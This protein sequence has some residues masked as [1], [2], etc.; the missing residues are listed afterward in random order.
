MFKLVK[1]KFKEIKYLGDSIGDDIRI[2]VE[3]L[4][5]FLRVD[6]KIKNGATV[7]INKE[8]AQIETNEKLFSTEIFINIFEKDLLFNDIGRV[9][10][11][12]KIDV[13]STKPQIFT[14]EIKI[15][16]THSNI[17]KPWSKA[18]A[19][20]EVKLEVEISDLMKFV[21]DEGE[22][23][24]KV[25]IESNKSKQSLPAY[26]KVKIEKSL[27]AKREYF[28]IL[29]GPYCGKLASVVFRTDGSSQ[30]V[31]KVKHEPVVHAVYS[32]SKKIFTLNGKKYQAEDY[33]KASWQNGLYD[34]E[35]PDFPHPGGRNYLSKSPRAIT[36]FRI[37]HKGDKYLHTGRFSLG[38]I[39][40]IENT[41]W[42]EI[43]ET[44]IKARKGD[45][46]SVGVLEVID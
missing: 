15:Q 23:W 4:G 22:G 36:W 2:E 27:N 9:K 19:I 17:G 37:G 45:S 31:S 8:V 28:T 30:F 35:I 40:I 24:L 3:T 39:T 34:I 5:N 10:S 11:K 42:M 38:C 26:L 43:Y 1:L 29:E 20:F 7:E 46:M 41:R 33:P 18:V 16:E 14:F 6:K 21:L 25:I 32:I 12:I 13:Y 44:L